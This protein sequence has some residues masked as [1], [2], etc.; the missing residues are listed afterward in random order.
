[1]DQIKNYVVIVRD[2]SLSMQ[3]L[4]HK[5]KDDYNE[6][7]NGIKR[8]AVEYEFDTIVSV[9]EC[10]HGRRAT[11]E[12]IV[13]NSSITALSPIKDYVT[14]GGSTPLFDSI[15][16][17][18]E[19]CKSTPDFNDPK[20][21]FLITAIT[22]GYENASHVWGS[23]KLDSEIRGLQATDRWTFTFRV[24]EGNYKEELLQTLKIPEGN[25]AEW[26]LTEKGFER[27]TR[28]TQSSF[29]NYYADLKSGKKSTGKFFT[30]L[31]NVS[32]TEVKKNLEDISK[33]VTVY[34]VG[35]HIPVATNAKGKI[36]IRP[37]IEYV[38]NVPFT[39]GSA[40]YELV[41]TEKVQGDKL[42]AIKHRKS[43]KV[44]S[45]NNARLLLG[46]SSYNADVA[47]GDHGDY[48]IFIQS[49]SVNRALPPGTRVLHWPSF[50]F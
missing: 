19:I 8:D 41:K 35:Q 6:L 47:P 36:E 11:V 37:F 44:Y 30:N 5:A 20:V 3:G 42:I 4:R 10:G 39:K 49:K 43:G 7:I 12:T 50:H 15:G 34:T 1:M 22:D 45:G 40:F 21:A 13:E 14:E 28:E 26:E 2:H 32:I 17:A 16:R 27:S 25:I 9:I 18:I 46:L 29:S 24:P 48:L 33:K 23:R 31:A 38:T